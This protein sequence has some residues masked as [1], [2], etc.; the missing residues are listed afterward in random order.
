LSVN[1]R[2]TSLVGPNTFFYDAVPVELPYHW[3]YQAR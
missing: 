2:Q 1:W 3:P